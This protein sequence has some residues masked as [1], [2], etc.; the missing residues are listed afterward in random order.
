MST[1]DLVGISK[2]Y[3]Q[4]AAV[5]GVDLSVAD[6]E[7]VTIL[8]PSGSGK[9]TLLN[10]VAGLI[11]PS[12]GR[13]FIAGRDVT[14]MPAGQRNVGLVFQSYALFPNMSVAQNIAFPLDVR[15]L[16]RAEIERRV[17]EALQMVRLG[18]ME[19]RR[20]NELSGGQQ[21]RVA[22]A[23][24]LVFEPDILLLDEP[25]AALDR[26]LREEVRVEL[27][28]LQRT[29]AI[30]TVLVTH[31]QEEA[32]SLSDRIVV[33]ESGRVRQAGQPDDAYRMPNSRF[34]A[35]FL[36]MA[37]FLEGTARRAG[38]AWS[39]ELADGTRVPCADPGRP[40]GA[41]VC[42][43]VRPER[44]RVGAGGEGLPATV[45]EAI[46]LGQSICYHL[47]LG[48]T[49]ELVSISLDHAARHAV[50]APVSV[51]WQP[52]DVWIIPNGKAERERRTDHDMQAV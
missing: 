16:S 46:F 44:V 7:F 28:R 24:A 47:A 43:V 14:D 36:G 10:L 51:T 31:D 6:G 52:E 49:L 5:E 35:D 48:R 41:A 1:I 27:R 15:G 25:L 21:Q 4:V 42:G 33:M 34:V 12:A 29:L 39:I 50:G 13:I 30:T 17:G 19:R 8:G 23:R 32:L 45:T 9:S 20:P 22:L 2:S 40:E 11:P 38:A 18:G 26:K 37:N 3:G